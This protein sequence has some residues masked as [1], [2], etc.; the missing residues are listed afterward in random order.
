[1]MQADLQVVVNALTGV[2][3]QR[4]LRPRRVGAVA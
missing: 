4:N 3:S 1:V 2:P